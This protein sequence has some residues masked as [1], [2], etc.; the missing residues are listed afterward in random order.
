MLALP[1]AAQIRTGEVSSSL[2]GVFSPGYTADFGNMTGSDHGW[3]IGGVA[4]YSGSYHNPNFL[5]FNATA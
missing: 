1:A 5:S 4:N 2:N 3:T